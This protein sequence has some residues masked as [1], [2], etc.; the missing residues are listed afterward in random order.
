MTPCAITYRAR[1][2]GHVLVAALS[3]VGVGCGRLS[4]VATSGLLEEEPLGRVDLNDVES[5]SSGCEGMLANASDFALLGETGLV[6]ALDG[7][8]APVCFDTVEAVNDELDDTGRAADA[9]VLSAR[10]ENTMTARRHSIQRLQFGGDPN[11]EPNAPQSTPR[12]RMSR[13]GI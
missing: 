1:L 11:P 5:A 6:V 3:L 13:P 10:Y 9:A 7:S 4:S 12:E 2:L 8:G